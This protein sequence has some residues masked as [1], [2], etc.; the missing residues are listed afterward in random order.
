MTLFGQDAVLLAL[1]CAG[2]DGVA[3]GELSGPSGV[4]EGSYRRHVARLIDQGLARREGAHGRIYAT[5]ARIE[6]VGDPARSA[7]G[8]APR[9]KLGSRR[10]HR[11]GPSRDLSLTRARGS[12]TSTKPSRRCP[13]YCKP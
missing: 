1:V 13:V 10:P 11:F 2:D 12:T 8:Q 9:V 7:Q 6:A 5:A 4:P 3:P